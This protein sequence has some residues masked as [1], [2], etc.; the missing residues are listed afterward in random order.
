MSSVTAQEINSTIV[1]RDPSSNR[2]ISSLFAT[3]NHCAPILLLVKDYLL[4]VPEISFASANYRPT[5]S[6]NPQQR[7]MCLEGTELLSATEFR[8]L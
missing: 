7:A 2:K 3:T 1:T 6:P 4:T 8:L 5:W